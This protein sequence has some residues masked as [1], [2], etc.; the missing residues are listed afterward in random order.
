MRQKSNS[1]PVT[2]KK[3]VRDNPTDTAIEVVQEKTGT[4]VWIPCHKILRD[5]FNADRIE[6]QYLLTSTR[7]D[8]FRA[9]SLTTMICNACTDFGFYIRRMGCGTWRAR[10]WRKPARP[11][12]RS[13]Q[14]WGT[15]P[16][17]R[18]A[19]HSTGPAQGHG[20]GRD[21]LVGSIEERTIN[22]K[23]QT[24]SARECQTH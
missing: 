18:P 14:S 22:G 7:G 9:T 1:T 4:Y 23:C 20:R 3:L 10:H 13:N 12:N 17:T 16:T 19:K 2:S 15:L 11:L 24:Y 21:A 6:G 8:R 5:H